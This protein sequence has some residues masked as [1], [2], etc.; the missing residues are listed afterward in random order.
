MRY[1][2]SRGRIMWEHGFVIVIIG[3]LNTKWEEIWMRGENES[4]W[5]YKSSIKEKLMKYMS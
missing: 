5:I 2:T 3:V 1:E 4:Q